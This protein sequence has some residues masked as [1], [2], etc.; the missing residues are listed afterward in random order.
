MTWF[1]TEQIYEYVDQLWH[2]LEDWSL[3]RIQM[4]EERATVTRLHRKLDDE[5]KHHMPSPKIAVLQQVETQLQQCRRCLDERL[6]R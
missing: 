6:K 3:N 4:R 5:L 1:E 2:S